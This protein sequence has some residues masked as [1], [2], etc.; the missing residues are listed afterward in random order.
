MHQ[1][2]GEALHSDLLDGADAIAE[3]LFGDRKKRRRVY[4]LAEAG[5]LPV[6]RLG[7]SICARRSVLRAYVEEQE[8]RAVTGE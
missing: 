7:Q 2:H 6:F 3:F 1:V 8:R 4:H 5:Q